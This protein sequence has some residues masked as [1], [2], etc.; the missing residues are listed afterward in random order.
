[1]VG[2]RRRLWAPSKRAAR[3]VTL[4]GRLESGVDLL[5]ELRDLLGQLL[6]LTRQVGVRLEQLLELLGRLLDRPLM[7]IRASSDLV[8][9]LFQ[10]VV[11]MPIAV[12]LA[13]LREQDP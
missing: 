12:G 13:R 7:F 4:A 9:M 2:V 5:R 6:V 1:M 11:G 8:A 3:R 10:H